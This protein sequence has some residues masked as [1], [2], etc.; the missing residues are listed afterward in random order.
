MKFW[1][2]CNYQKFFIFWAKNRSLEQCA[3]AASSLENWRL[4]CPEQTSLGVKRG[5]CATIPLSLSLGSSSAASSS[6]MHANACRLCC[7]GGEARRRWLGA[8]VRVVAIFWRFQSRPVFFEAVRQRSQLVVPLHCTLHVYS[9]KVMYPIN[10]WV[11]LLLF[12]CK[13]KLQA[14]CTTTIS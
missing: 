10:L 4:L 13:Y 8:F 2:T 7:G 11:C 14:W 5:H 12:Y 1:Q 9:S 6:L 3:V